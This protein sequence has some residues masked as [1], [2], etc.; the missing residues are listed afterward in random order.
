MNGGWTTDRGVDGVGDGGGGPATLTVSEGAAYGLTISPM[1][2]MP[3]SP[4]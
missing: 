4:A 3:C 1:V 2:Q